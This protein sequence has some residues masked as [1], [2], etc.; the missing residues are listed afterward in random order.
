MRT[1]KKTFAARLE[2]QASEAD[3][4]GM[5]KL[6]SHLRST[7]KSAPKR[8]ND[9]SYIYSSEDLAQDVEG[10]LWDAI[11]RTADFFDCNVD[12][13]VVQNVVETYSKHLIDEIRL[14]GGVKH[15]IGAYEPAVPG[16]TVKRAMIEVSEDDV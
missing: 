12:A 5:N 3:L 9:G 8:E 13:G 16:E 4:Q 10:K 2:A 7:V 11:I 1:I 14:H 15:G 6:A